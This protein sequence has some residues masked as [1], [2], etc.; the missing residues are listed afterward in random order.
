M[1]QDPSPMLP[2]VFYSLAGF[3][4]PNLVITVTFDFSVSSQYLEKSYIFILHMCACTYLLFTDMHVNV[5]IL[6][7]ELCSFELLI[8]SRECQPITHT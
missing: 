6:P 1:A 3:Y 8:T 7:L 5:T 2:S 4:V